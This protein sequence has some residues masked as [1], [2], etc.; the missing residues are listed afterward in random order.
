MTELVLD[1]LCAK[2]IREISSASYLLL[3]EES[4]TEDRLFIT[5]LIY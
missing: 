2:K 5:S 1:G 4:S 3:S